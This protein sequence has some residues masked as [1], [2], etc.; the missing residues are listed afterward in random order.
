[1]KEEPEDADLER[2]GV[3]SVA[4]DYEDAKLEGWR[5]IDDLA[6]LAD[7]G[8]STMIRVMDCAVA[9][10]KWETIKVKVP[11][12]WKAAAYWEILTE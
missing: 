3:E 8:R 11:G 7:C 10:G 6:A 5:T 4:P 12:G 2:V 9:D 1:M